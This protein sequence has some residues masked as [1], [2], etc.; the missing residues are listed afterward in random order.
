MNIERTLRR[1]RYWRYLINAA[2]I[3]LLVVTGAIGAFLLYRGTGTF[4]QYGHSLSEFLFSTQ[5]NPADTL[6]GGGH[7]GAGI[8]IVGSLLTCALALLIATPVSIGLA[9]YMAEITPRY[10]KQFWQP[11][12]EIFV[13]IPSVIYGWMGLTVLV[14]FIQK[15]TESASGF[16]VL[17]ASIVLALMIF[18]TI[19]SVTMNALNAVPKTYRQGAYG[20]GATRF[21]VITKI[22]L[23]V[24]KSG[25]MAG[26]VL[27]LARAFGEALA[28][29]M[30][31]GKMK[32]LPHSLLDPTVNLTG[33]IAADMGGTMEG[34]EFNMALWSM[35]LL[36]FVISLVF[37]LLIRYISAKGGAAVEGR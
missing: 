25:I 18:P 36:L 30:V 24:A 26:I 20:L 29:A 31:I 15:H 7:V 33:A 34:S 37:I 32:A 28:V 22:V 9:V 35:A 14:P 17:A 21:E 6:A 19:T 5:W 2:G 8:F 4:T 10:G 13:G 27:G 12:V 23:P 1:D 3:F 16:S 11:V